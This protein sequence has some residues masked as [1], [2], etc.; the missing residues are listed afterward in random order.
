MD[1]VL[2]AAGIESLLEATGGVTVEYDGQTTVGHRDRVD[3]EEF[4]GEQAVVQAREALVVPTGSLTGLRQGA[5]ITADGTDWLVG[6]FQQVRDG[7]ET[8][9][10]LR[11]KPGA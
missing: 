10:Q 2:T 8:V 7:R 11:T 1:D 4:Q 5:T 6:P 9:I 3:V